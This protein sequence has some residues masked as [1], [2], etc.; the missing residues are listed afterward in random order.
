MTV[1]ATAIGCAFLIILASI[2]FGA[3]KYIQG[4]ILQN[5]AVTEV[6]V[7]G[8]EDGESISEEHIEELQSVANVKAVTRQSYLLNNRARITYGQF[9]FDQSIL[10]VDFPSEVKAG[11]ELEEGRMPEKDGE[12]LIGHHTEQ[13]FYVEGAKEEASDERYTEEGVVKEEFRLKNSLVGEEVTLTIEQYKDDEWVSKDLTLTVVG[14]KKAPSRDWLRDVDV[15]VSQSTLS[16]VEAFTG[17]PNGLILDPNMSEEEQKSIMADS[18]NSY[19]EVKVIAE[20]IESVSSISEELKEQ[21]YFIYSVTE[22]LN[23]VNTVFAVVKIGLV[24]IGTIALLI[25]SIGIYNTMNMA[26]TER[27]QDIGIMKAIGGQPKMIRQIFLLESGAIGV[28][29]A[30]VGLVVAYLISI[31][32]NFM[33]PYVIEIAFGEGVEEAIQLSYIPLS[34]VVICVTLCVGIAVLS[35]MKPARKATR[36]DVLR[37]L[38][39]DL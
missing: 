37:A 15:Y 23:Q 27:T 21:G 28:I 38:R 4:E 19:Q 8:T 12:I 24:L 39:R 3:Q 13:L 9:Q 33:L 2:G 25:A 26:V 22:E 6:S 18:N 16:A 7:H 14:K 32:I 10:V 31:G 11:V 1:L 29:G 35:G 30:F 34:L 5:Q 36:I 20:D 17:T